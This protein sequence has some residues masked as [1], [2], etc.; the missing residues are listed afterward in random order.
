LEGEP[1]S[2]KELRSAKEKSHSTQPAVHSALPAAYLAMRIAHSLSPVLPPLPLRLAPARTQRRHQA[3]PKP[4]PTHL[5]ATT[6]PQ[7]NAAS[8]S[9]P[10]LH[11]TAISGR[12]NHSVRSSLHNALFYTLLI[13]RLSFRNE[14]CLPFAANLVCHSAANCLSFR[15]ELCLSFASNLVCHSAAKRRNLLLAVASCCCL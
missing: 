12:Y 14:L 10:N 2:A 7:S 3:Q 13:L 11:A 15:N 8:N 9:P 4:A 5:C 6:L 1:C